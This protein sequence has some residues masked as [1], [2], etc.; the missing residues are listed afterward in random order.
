MKRV[1]IDPAS[2][3]KAGRTAAGGAGNGSAAPGLPYRAAGDRIHQQAAVRLYTR[4]GYQTRSA[5]AVSTRSAEPVYGE[6][7][8]CRSSFSCAIN[9]S[10]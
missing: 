10:S 7:A 8:R 1:F 5:F 6:T 9:A 2:R 4:W 3:A